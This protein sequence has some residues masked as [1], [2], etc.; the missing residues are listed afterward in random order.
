V[1]KINPYIFLVVCILNIILTCNPITIL[2]LAPI[3]I[4][5]FI[6]VLKVDPIPSHSHF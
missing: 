5:F 1:E 2:I 3:F 4:L 6:L